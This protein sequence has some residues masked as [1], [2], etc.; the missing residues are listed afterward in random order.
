M[1]S[2]DA[3]SVNNSFSAVKQMFNAIKLGILLSRF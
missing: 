2:F 3:L 1:T